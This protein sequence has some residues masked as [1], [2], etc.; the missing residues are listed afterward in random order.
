[1][2]FPTSSTQLQQDRYYAK[3]RCSQR[4]RVNPDGRRNWMFAGHAHMSACPVLVSDCPPFGDQ[5]FGLEFLPTTGPE[6]D[7]G[8]PLDEVTLADALNEAGYVTGMVGTSRKQSRQAMRSA[9]QLCRESN[10]TRFACLRIAR[11]AHHA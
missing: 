4:P 7:D 8:P 1:M 2:R 6:S 5:R 11:R 10:S 9:E 3:P